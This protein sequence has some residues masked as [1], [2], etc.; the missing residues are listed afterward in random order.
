MKNILITG[1]TGLVGTHLISQLLITNKYKIRVLTRDTKKAKKQMPLPIDFYEWDID[2][3]KIDSKSVEGVDFVIHLAGEN[4][5]SYW[6]EKTK[7]RILDSRVG[8]TKLL[9]DSLSKYPNQKTKFIQASAIGIYGNSGSLFVNE[10]DEPAQGYLANVC[11]DWEKTLLDDIN[12]ALTKAIIR[13]GIVLSTQGGALQKMLPP[14]KFNLGGI[15]GN[16][17]QYMSWIHIDDL[18][19][20]FIYLIE[21]ET[22]E[23]IFNGVSTSP[24]TNKEFTKTLNK[25]LNKFTF[26]PVPKFVLKTVLGEMSQIVLNSQRIK[27]ESFYKNSFDFKFTDLE[28][29]L[30]NLLRY[31]RNG[32]G[33]LIEHQWIDKPLTEV[34][35]FFKD[36]KNLEKITPE[37]LQFKILSMNTKEIKE[38]SLI[39]Y[40]LKLHGIPFKWRTLISRF[41]E[42]EMFID[43]QQKG[44]YKK[45]VH[46]HTFTEMNGGTLINDHVVY[47]LPLGSLGRTVAGKFVK[48]DVESIFSYRKE[49]IDKHFSNKR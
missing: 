13:I 5:A 41:K 16:G 21:N 2:L 37:Y 3:K 42:N 49:V 25:S 27:P 28:S 38:G 9:L 32:E 26:L 39:H 22:K 1:A 46:T 4:V 17:K 29:A 8:S 12:P 19:S 10:M 40:K 43:Q 47:K 44:P 30:N 14:F 7:K 20:M 48:N 34:F 24:V 35:D 18:V 11:K 6:T 45:W 36:A 23:T 33:L 15:L 31:E